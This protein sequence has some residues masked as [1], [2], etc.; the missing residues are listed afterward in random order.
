MIIVL[1]RVVGRRTE[2]I[3]SLVYKRTHCLLKGG[4]NTVFIEHV[5]ILFIIVII[6]IL[7]TVIVIVIV[8][9]VFLKNPSCSSFK[10]LGLYHIRGSVKRRANSRRQLFV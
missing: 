5:K 1:I 3:I 9:A 10:P 7:F 8:I 6:E 2:S 4:S